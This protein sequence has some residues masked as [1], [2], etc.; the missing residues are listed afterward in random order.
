[1]FIGAGKKLGVNVFDQNRLMFLSGIKTSKH[2]RV[3]AGFL[4]QVLQQGRLVNN[5]AV[6]QKNT[7]WLLSLYI[8]V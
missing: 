4:Q 6:F 3:E 5:R 8:N 1:L 7:G 2:I